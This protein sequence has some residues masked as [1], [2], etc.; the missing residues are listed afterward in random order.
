MSHPQ[1]QSQKVKNLVV[2]VIQFS[3]FQMRTSVELTIRYGTAEKKCKVTKIRTEI[4]PVKLTITSKLPD[5]DEAG[6]LITMAED[7]E[8]MYR[9]DATLADEFCEGLGLPEG[10]SAAELAAWTMVTSAIYNL[11]I[12][13]TRE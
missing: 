5:A 7:L 1:S 3:N 6:V 9:D 10:A 13:R 12:T 4:D 8:A 11:D 2:E